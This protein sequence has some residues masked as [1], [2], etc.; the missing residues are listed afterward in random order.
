M[1]FAF[2][3]SGA[4]GFFLVAAVGL[5]SGRDIELVL[6]DAAVS[7]LL[8]AFVGRWFWHGL[9]T[10]FAHTLA[11]NRD[12]AE[13]AAE[14]PPA[15][16]AVATAPAAKPAPPAKPPASPVPSLSGARRR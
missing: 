14:P 12:A 16:P 8:C 6:R 13:A 15:T 10:A 11:A 1:R 4:F 9:E 3:L 7:C 5:A 2:L